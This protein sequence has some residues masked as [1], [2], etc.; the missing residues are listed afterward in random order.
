LS[1]RILFM[2]DTAL[3]NPYTLY[4][5]RHPNAPA[6]AGAFAQWATAAGRAAIVG[7][8]LPDGTAAFDVL[9]G[10]CAALATGQW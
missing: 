1:L 9:A 5:V 10:G 2:A 6:A 3:T 7:L 4:V 8:R